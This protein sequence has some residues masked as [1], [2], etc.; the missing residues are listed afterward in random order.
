MAYNYDLERE[1]INR[2][3]D[4]RRV[5]EDTARRANR[6]KQAVFKENMKRKGFRQKTVWVKDPPEDMIEV[7]AVIH[8]DVKGIAD[9][10]T[11]IGEKLKFAIGD[12]VFNRKIISETLYADIMVLL[13]PLGKTFQESYPGSPGYESENI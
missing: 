1:R 5:K 11:E 6:T 7:T 3:A 8:K 2:Q 13:K 9:R 12:L 4:E 10:N